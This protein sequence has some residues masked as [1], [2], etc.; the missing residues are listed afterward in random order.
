MF[1]A[2]IAIIPHGDYVISALV[3]FGE[4]GVLTHMVV[5]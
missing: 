4:Q 5:E 2:P 3:E 1:L